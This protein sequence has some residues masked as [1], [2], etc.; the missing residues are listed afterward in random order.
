MQTFH[1][2]RIDERDGGAGW[3]RRVILAAKERR[4]HDR[5]GSAQ[6]LEPPC[7][8][9]RH[10]EIAAKRQALKRRLLEFR[11]A[12]KS[13][14]VKIRDSR[15]VNPGKGAAELEHLAVLADGDVE[16]RQ[17]GHDLPWSP[18][19]KYRVAKIVVA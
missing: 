2:D 14:F 16:P 17:L 6:P 7:D 4:H 9:P 15:N 19:A 11:P 1:R 3:A 10:R 13:K 12:L 18:T 8:E 5:S